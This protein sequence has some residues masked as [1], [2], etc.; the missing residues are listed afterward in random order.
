MAITKNRTESDEIVS[1]AR[2]RKALDQIEMDINNLPTAD[3][4]EKQQ[5]ISRVLL[6]EKMITRM[7]VM[8]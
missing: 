8:S 2:M 4:T 7:L 5:I 6:W 1:R 3:E